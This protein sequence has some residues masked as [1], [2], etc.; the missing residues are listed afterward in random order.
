MASPTPT[1]KD[2]NAIESEFAAALSQWDL[3]ITAQNVMCAYPISDIYAAAPRFLYYCLLFATFVTIRYRWLSNVFLGAAVAYA[4]SAAIHS[5]II[6][7]NPS[8]APPGQDVAIPFIPSTS[9]LTNVIPALI[10]NT[11]TVSIQPDAVELDIDPITAVVVTAY[12]VGLPLQLWSRTMRSSRIVR[13]MI[14]LFNLCMLA[15]TVCTLVSWPTTNLS[16]PQYRFCFAGIPDPDSF[17]N[18]GWNPSLWQGTWNST[19]WHIFDN[20]STVWQNL[21]ANCYYPCSNSSQVI[22][23]ATSLKAVVATPETPFAKLHNPYR[24]GTD[25]FRPLVYF[26]IIL[27]SAAQAFLYLVSVLRL[28]SEALRSTI[29]EPTRAW[30]R[31][32]RVGL[33][34][35][36]DAS[37]SWATIKSLFLGCVPRRLRSKR[38]VEAS[39]TTVANSPKP[40]VNDILVPFRLFIDVL[41]LVIVFAGLTLFPVVVVAFICWIEWYIRNDGDTNET[42]K[43]VGQWAPLVSVAVVLMATTL[44]RLQKRLADKDELAREI[45]DLEVRIRTLKGEL[46]KRGVPQDECTGFEMT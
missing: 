19:V 26:A 15:G 36:R 16:A 28:G 30:D 25:E 35:R 5:F 7:S 29:H 41:A 23:Q 37:R 39:S 33:Q 12:L 46:E 3:T 34:L 22:R 42:I 32:A 11:S 44:Y 14:L 43:Q 17:Q 24:Y 10:T 31:R 1:S 6:V 8:V 13:Y 20:P 27:F 18:D 4:A 21:S 45:R 38:E 9:N 2:A 40:E